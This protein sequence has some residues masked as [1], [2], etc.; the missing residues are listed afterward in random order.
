M[1]NLRDK[2]DD[3]RDVGRKKESMRMSYAIIREYSRKYFHPKI[4]RK[5]RIFSL[6]GKNNILLK[7]V[8]I[9]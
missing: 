3:L 2:I 5:V 8:Y 1:D 6:G 9:N 4:G 7:S